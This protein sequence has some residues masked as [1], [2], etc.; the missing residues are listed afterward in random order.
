MDRRC[1]DA[2]QVSRRGPKVIYLPDPRQK[3]P[4]K[5]GLQDAPTGE[6]CPAVIH[7]ST[8][9][10]IATGDLAADGRGQSNRMHAAEACPGGGAAWRIGAVPAW[11]RS[12]TNG[13]RHTGTLQI[14][15]LVLL[16]LVGR[17][18][19]HIYT[20]RPLSP[21]TGT[22]INANYIIYFDSTCGM[23]QKKTSSVVK[24]RSQDEH[25]DYSHIVAR[26]NENDSSAHGYVSEQKNCHMATTGVCMVKKQY[27]K[28]YHPV[29]TRVKSM[30]SG[31]ISRQIYDM[32][33]ARGASTSRS[34]LQGRSLWRTPRQEVGR[35]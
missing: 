3:M 6:S 22:D 15:A 14:H 27:A 31:F 2:V 16:V 4:L 12:R 29:Q 33:T 8:R 23:L 7:Q 18:L 1:R 5:T 13:T 17:H 19:R 21:A 24:M 10:G 32:R 35:L 28:Q 11:R 26:S 25:I 20:L 9:I 30:S 34:P